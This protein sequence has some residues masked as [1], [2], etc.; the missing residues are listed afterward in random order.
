MT[1][2][3][4]QEEIKFY[5]SSFTHEGLNEQSSKSLLIK[6]YVLSKHNYLNLVPLG[7]NRTNL[8]QIIK[9]QDKFIV[10]LIK[11]LEIFKISDFPI[12]ITLVRDLRDISSYISTSL[13]FS[14]IKDSKLSKLEGQFFTPANLIN[15]IC[16]G[17]GILKETKKQEYVSVLD[18]SAGLGDFLS[19]LIPNNKIHNYA[20]ELDELTFEFMFFNILLD[21]TISQTKRAKTILTLKQGDALKGYQTVSLGSFTK[22]KKG[23]DLLLEYK[24]IREISLNC[25][26]ITFNDVEKVV[27]LRHQIS[28]FQPD[29]HEFNWYID[30]PE[31][32][33]DSK[34]Q[35]K[36]EN[37]FDFVLGNPPWIKFGSFNISEYKNVFSHSLFIN[38]LRGKFNFSLPFII[39]GYNLTKNKGALVVPRGIVTET[40]ASKWRE[41]IVKDKSLSNLILSASTGF[42]D[43]I[44]EYSLIFW[45]KEQK[46]DF[47][48][49]YDE[50]NNRMMEVDFKSIKSPLFRIPLIPMSIYQSLDKIFENS[51]PLK[52]FCE[53]RRGLTLTKKY[54]IFYRNKDLK[55]FDRSKVK[56]LIR[57]N[58][59]SSTRKEG[60]A[61][62]QVFYVGEQFVY[63]KKLLGAPG[64]ANIFERNKIIRRNRGKKWLIGL[65]LTDGYY[66][67]DIF[68]IIYTSD[69]SKLLTIFGYLSSSLVQFLMETYIQRDITSNQLRE[70]P[71]PDLEKKDKKEVETAVNQWINSRKNKKNIQKLRS[72]MDE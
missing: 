14:Y 10:P 15:Q 37:V 25:N 24:K 69:L 42:K 49:I 46:K 52:N 43:V 33:F 3:Q 63:D 60:V 22:T 11:K 57:H 29:F 59:S 48:Q 50:K 54:Q 64:T 4:E 28:I 65:D 21:K 34:M 56:K 70:L 7:N 1:S 38:Q 13:F 2:F 19:V 67:N 5:I 40:Y 35:L 53:I 17:L 31:I 58:N 71:Y 16:S 18:C 51:Q 45:D 23:K 36:T 44:N 39:L 27:D 68:D 30:F 41:K 6:L 62:F 9:N 8:L 26:E 55:S 61:D 47:F 12:P 32:F 20:V 66:V 72:K